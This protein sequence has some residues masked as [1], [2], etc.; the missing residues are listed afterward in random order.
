MTNVSTRFVPGNVAANIP[1]NQAA[2]TARFDDFM[3]Q[4]AFKAGAMDFAG[5]FLDRIIG[6]A[7]S[8]SAL[9]PASSKYIFPFSSAFEATFGTSGPL[10][11]FINATTARLNLSA[12][13]NLALQNI[14]INNKDATRTPEHVQKIARELAAAGIG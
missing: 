10:L 4:A 3:A 6:S 2:G 14:A 8:G 1:K 7:P 11:D 13:K 12:E 9:S 5:D